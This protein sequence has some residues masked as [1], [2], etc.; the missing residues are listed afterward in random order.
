MWLSILYLVVCICIANSSNLSPLHNYA[1]LNIIV[2][3]SPILNI[4]YFCVCHVLGATLSLKHHEAVV[5]SFLL[6]CYIPLK[7]LIPH[8][9]DSGVGGIWIASMSV[10][11]FMRIS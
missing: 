10:D 4:Q 9:V 7:L 2:L 8:F 11:S 6:L 3:F 5:F 1:F